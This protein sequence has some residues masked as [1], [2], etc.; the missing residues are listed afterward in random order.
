[1]PWTAGRDV[2]HVI[3]IDV[4]G[5]KIAGAVVTAR[6]DLCYSLLEPTRAREGPETLMRRLIAMAAQLRDRRPDVAAI[7]VASAGQIDPELGTVVYANRN[8]PGWT[9][10]PIAAR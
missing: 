9:G 8:L 7:G 4:G 3:G 1:M 5:T 2:M 6:G 10:M